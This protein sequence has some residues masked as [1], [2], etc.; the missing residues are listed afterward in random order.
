LA[1]ELK[2]PGTFFTITDADLVPGGDKE[3]VYTVRY[4]TTEDADRIREACTPKKFDSATGRIVDNVPDVNEHNKKLAL[5]ILDFVLKDWTG[6]FDGDQP[7]PCTIENKTL[8]PG[9]RRLRLLQLAQENVEV[10]AQ[11]KAETF[12]DA[13]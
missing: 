10:K 1:L 7:M 6:V 5:A 4:Y 13:S 8:L 2:R 9:T 3:T 11:S 12:R